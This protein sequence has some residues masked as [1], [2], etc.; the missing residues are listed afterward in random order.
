MRAAMQAG[1]P[2]TV[3]EATTITGVSPPLGAVG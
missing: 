2:L 1:E 3:D